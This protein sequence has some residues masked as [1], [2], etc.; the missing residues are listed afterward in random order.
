M[1][2][3]QIPLYQDV[4]WIF[5]TLLALYGAGLSTY[6]KWARHRELEPNI[7]VLLYPSEGFG[8]PGPPERFLAIHV[9][10][11]GQPD[12]IFHDNSRSLLVKTK[13]TRL[14]VYMAPINAKFPV[15]LK[16]GDAF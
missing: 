7:K 14:A 9:K 15:T 10:N 6:E 2:D 5:T 11:T 1:P 3:P 12:V 13:D 8:A 16:H 4:R